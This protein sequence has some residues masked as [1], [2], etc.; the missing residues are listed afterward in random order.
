MANVSDLLAQLERERRV[1]AYDAYDII[2]RQ[3]VDMLRNGEIDISPDYQRQFIWKEARESELIESIFLGIPI[4]SLYMAVNQSDG[5]WEVVD[6]VQRLSTIMHFAGDA[7]F[8]KRINRSTPLRLEGLDKLSELNGVSYEDLP[9][10]ARATFLNRGLRVTTLNDRS[11]FN[12]RF[13]LFERL[14]TGGVGLHDQEIRTILF[15]GSFNQLLKELAERATF[16]SVVKLGSGKTVSD[17]SECVLRFFAFLNNYM[18]FD[19]SVKEFLNGYMEANLNGPSVPDVDLFEATFQFL[20]GELTE[21]IKR[22]GR[23]ATPINL[24]EAIAVGTA[25]AIRARG[26]NTPVAGRVALLLADQHLRTFTSAG[27]NSKQMVRNRIEY[28]RDTLV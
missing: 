28:V 25:L 15:R 12:V 16:R 4:P 26:G 10:A 5:S 3:L 6:G 2:V 8:L 22:N 14:N 17:Y 27:T 20:S 7:E 24:Y 1:V 19:H 21:G 11:D 18:N 13:D 23:G 9:S